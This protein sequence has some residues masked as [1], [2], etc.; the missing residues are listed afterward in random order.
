MAISGAE[1][2]PFGDSGVPPFVAVPIPALIAE[3]ADII[4][5]YGEI[6]FPACPRKLVQPR[7]TPSSR[8]WAVRHA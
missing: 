2:L 6:Q 8:R 3:T 4:S 7:L 1:C 5:S